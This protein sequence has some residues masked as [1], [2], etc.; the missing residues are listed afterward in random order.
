MK[1]NESHDT[2]KSVTL[3][4]NPYKPVTSG[5]KMYDLVSQ[6]VKSDRD[7]MKHRV[8]EVSHQYITVSQMSH[9]P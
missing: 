7:F 1:S 5:A 8:D 3:S 6:A 4:H 2:L 9:F